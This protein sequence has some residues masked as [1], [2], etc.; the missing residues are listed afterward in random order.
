MNLRSFISDNIINI[1]SDSENNELQKP[2]SPEV[3][4]KHLT[5]S[6]SFIN[7]QEVDDVGTKSETM[8]STD[9]LTEARA[10]IAKV[11]ADHNQPGTDYFE[12]ILAK[13]AMSSIP[14][15]AERYKVAFAGLA[16]TG[17]TLEIINNS[18]NYYK[19]IINN[20]LKDFQEQFGQVFKTEV[21]DKKT[22]IAGKQKQMVQLSEQINK[23][24]D[25]IKRMNEEAQN[26]ETTFTMKKNSFEQVVA[27]MQNNI[28]TELDKINQYIQ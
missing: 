15:E 22:S 8:V 9:A 25:E 2:I 13:N 1:G 21:V 12:L 18:A 5:I 4:T 23:L 6:K 26:S 11:I 24:N 7:K 28:Q 19:T 20:E 14:V 27:E 3:Q 17:L 16:A 10:R